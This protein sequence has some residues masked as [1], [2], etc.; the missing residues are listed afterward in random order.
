MKVEFIECD[1][2]NYEN[3]YNEALNRAAAA[4]KDEDRHLKATLE[5]IFPE[6][7]EEDG[8]ERT[9]KEI[10]RFIQMEV[11]DEIVGNKWIA[12]L[13]KQSETD[14]TKAKILLIN[15]GYPIDVNGTFPTYEQVYN[16]IKEGLE[17]QGERISANSCKTCKDEQKPIERE[18]FISI[19]FG[20][21]SELVNETIT[22]PD[23]CVATIEGNRI[24]IKKK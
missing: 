15:K 5:R 7:K 6:L 9:R 2:M 17:K 8:D 22:I 23:G 19:P 18:G 1:N 20:T 13:E 12:W 4:Y 11:E 24:H 3:K 10:V 21:D 14:E 16:I